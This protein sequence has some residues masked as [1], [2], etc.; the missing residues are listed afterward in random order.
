M[1][2]LT[3]AAIAAGASTLAWLRILFSSKHDRLS[4]HAFA[5]RRALLLLA[6]APGHR[7]PRLRGVLCDGD[8]R[9]MRE[10]TRHAHEP[11]AVRGR[12]QR[13]SCESSAGWRAIS[14]ERAKSHALA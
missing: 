12:F 4:E 13:A 8:E 9:V 5:P 11:R 3:R 14:P 10:C 6:T 1:E 7:L 2:S